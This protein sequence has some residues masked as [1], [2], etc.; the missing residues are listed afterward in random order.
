MV[1]RSRLAFL[2]AL[3]CAVV[4]PATPA[5]AAPATPAPAP[6]REGLRTVGLGDWGHGG[7]VQDVN[8]PGDVAGALNDENAM[9][10]PVLWGRTGD[11]APVGVGP[12]GAAAV[13]NRGDA[14][15]DNW[16]WIGG[17]LLTLTPPSG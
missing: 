4:A 5:A 16:L 15:G 10:Q 14:V 9:P 7:Y 13:N 3:I 2:A 11:P 1:L 8:D 12:G 6:A 17:K